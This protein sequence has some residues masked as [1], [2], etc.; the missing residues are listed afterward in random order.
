MFWN[1][2]TSDDKQQAKRI[3]DLESKRI[4]DL[5]SENRSL[6]NMVFTSYGIH[7]N[8]A[9]KK[10]FGILKAKM[11]RMRRRV[12]LLELSQKKMEKH[13]NETDGA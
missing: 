12:Y 2:K 13:L 3:I 11:D 7:S 6:W 4:I 1:R 5:E 9:D 8:K 10:Q